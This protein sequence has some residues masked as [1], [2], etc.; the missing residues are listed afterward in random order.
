MV[1]KVY[2]KDAK[3][4]SGF[5]R[6]GINMGQESLIR[7]PDSRL[8]CLKLYQVSGQSKDGK[9]KKKK[10]CLRHLEWAD[11]RMYSMLSST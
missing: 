10:T 4:E 1:D 9:I 7:Q 3:C 6:A 11:T 8:Q 5:K 2:I